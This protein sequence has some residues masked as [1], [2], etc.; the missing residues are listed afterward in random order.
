VNDIG[1]GWIKQQVRWEHVEGSKGDYGF[2]G[3]DRLADTANAGGVKVLFSVVAAPGWA[4]G[5]K[6]GVGPPDN[7]QD[8]Y[9]FMGALA[10]HFRGRVHAYEI[11]NE[12]NL[13]R[14]W[15]GAPL[16]ASDYVRLLRGAYQAVKAADPNAIVVSGAPTPTGISDGNWA[17]DDRTYLQQMYNAGLRYYCDA[18]G[19]HPSGYA[20][21]PD[22]RYAGGDFDPSRGYD[23]HPSFFFRNTMEDYYNI[24][25]ANGDGGKRI[26]ATE[27]GW[28]TT[29]GMGVPAS[30]GYEFADDISE[31]QQAD[32]IVRA[33]TWSRSWGH[34]GVMFLWNLNFW[35]V[36][37]PK[38]EM[39]KYG[40]VRGDWSPRPAYI[41]L[42]NMPK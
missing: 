2:G 23:D 1:F 20:N 36:T 26:W 41:A 10:S 14:E 22:V 17:I 35:P 39:A 25:A 28:A 12:Q 31:G 18:V 34:A 15:E 3:L 37:G 9:D 33:Y 40:I 32:Y 16:S 19:A 30:E 38:N 42:Q 29:D 5:G 27:F 4:R 21:P 7:Y 6:S 8:F 11:W 24:M 13:K